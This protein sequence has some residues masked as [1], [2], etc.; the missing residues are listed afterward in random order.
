MIGLNDVVV[1]VCFSHLEIV[2]CLRGEVIDW[3]GVME[4][5]AEQMRSR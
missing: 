4:G 1:S 5:Y 2:S 3:V